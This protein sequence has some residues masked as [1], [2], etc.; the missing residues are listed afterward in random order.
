[1]NMC[2][3]MM[4]NSNITNGSSAQARGGGGSSSNNWSGKGHQGAH[5]SSYQDGEPAT[6]LSGMAAGNI[7]HS[8]YFF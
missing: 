5:T 3:L 8:Y 7:D 1:M 6:A 2:I 4:A